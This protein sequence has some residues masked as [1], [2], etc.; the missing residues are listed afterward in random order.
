MSFTSDMN[1]YQTTKVFD[2][3]LAAREDGNEDAA[4]MLDPLA[5]RYFTPSELLKLF[6]FV[7]LSEPNDSFDFV[8]PLGISLKSKYRLIGNSINVEVSN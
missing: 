3:F 2:E 7:D 1:F 6:H 4:R 8:W 5:L